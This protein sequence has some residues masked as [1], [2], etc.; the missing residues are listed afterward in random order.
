MVVAGG[1]ISGKIVNSVG[2]SSRR[3]MLL[4]YVMSLLLAS[5]WILFGLSLA[6][7]RHDRD[8]AWPIVAATVVWVFSI[9]HGG[10]LFNRTVV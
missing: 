10:R 2:G 1:E 5:T 7:S 3:A 9:L 8:F 4:F 6:D